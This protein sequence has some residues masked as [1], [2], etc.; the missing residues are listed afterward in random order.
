MGGTSGGGT[1]RCSY[2]LK[3][4]G[5]SICPEIEIKFIVIHYKEA[6]VYY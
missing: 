6:V 4:S 2:F 3:F 1:K 5:G